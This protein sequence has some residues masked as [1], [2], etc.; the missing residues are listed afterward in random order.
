MQPGSS[1]AILGQL[2]QHLLGRGRRALRR[3]GDDRQPSSSKKMAPICF[4]EPMLNR[5]PATL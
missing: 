5:C 1:M 3:L 2:L 4:G